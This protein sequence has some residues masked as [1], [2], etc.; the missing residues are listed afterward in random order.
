M[1]N[2]VIRADAS[3]KIGTGHVMRCLTLASELKNKYKLA[4]DWINKAI[5]YD[6][7]KA[8]NYASILEDRQ[9]KYEKIQ[10]QLKK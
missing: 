2:V 1:M 7:E 3:L 6:N 4:L 5:S 9:S 10:Q 8:Q